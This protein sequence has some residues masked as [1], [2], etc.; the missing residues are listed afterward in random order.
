[1]TIIIW[2]TSV[3]STNTFL[4]AKMVADALLTG[5]LPSVGIITDAPNVIVEG[6][7]FSAVTFPDAGAPTTAQMGN[8]AFTDLGIGITIAESRSLGARMPNCAPNWHT[9]PSPQSG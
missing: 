3:S 4:S 8:M 7:S 9:E 1:M 6:M 5:L 2:C